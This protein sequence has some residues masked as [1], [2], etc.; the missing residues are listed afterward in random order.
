MDFSSRSV[1]LNQLITV[2]VCLSPVILLTIGY[3]VGRFGLPIEIKRRKLRDRRK[4]ARSNSIDND[5]LEV[6][7]VYK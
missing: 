6:V 4:N 1:T 5:D 3:A 7:E 2:L